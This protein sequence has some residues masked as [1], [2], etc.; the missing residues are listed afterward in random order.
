MKSRRLAALSEL[1]PTNTHYCTFP[2]AHIW[3]EENEKGHL[4]RGNHLQLYTGQRALTPTWLCGRKGHSGELMQLWQ[5]FCVCESFWAVTGIQLGIL[6]TLKTY[7]Y[8]YCFQ[9][10]RPAAIV[11]WEGFDGIDAV[12][13]LMH[14]FPHNIKVA[15]VYGLLQWWRL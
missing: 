14:K 9:R 6:Q 7:L 5:H 4:T 8:E 3:P 10:S 2:S 15:S 1:V 12:W 11:P 13:L